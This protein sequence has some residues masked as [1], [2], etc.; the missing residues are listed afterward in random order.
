MTEVYLAKDSVKAKIA[1]LVDE[2]VEAHKAN[3]E[4]R[5]KS[6]QDVVQRLG[7]S[8]TARGPSD[9]GTSHPLDR[10]QT[11]ASPRSVS[12]NSNP[13]LLAP[14]VVTDES[15]VSVR[16]PP[17]RLSQDQR[18]VDV[19]D[20]ESDRIQLGAQFD[21][22]KSPQRKWSPLERLVDRI[23]TFPPRTEPKPFTR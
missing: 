19:I 17:H 2:L 4:T 10:L 23:S 8:P 3:E 21:S 11:T 15:D 6:L 12:S 7:Q 14:S 16:T 20:P 9:R 18:H 22:P 1:K 5:R 13:G